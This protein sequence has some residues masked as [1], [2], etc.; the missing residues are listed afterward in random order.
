MAISNVT[1]A[2]SAFPMA[3]LIRRLA[4]IAH[5]AAP[6]YFAQAVAELDNS[7]ETAAHGLA[8]LNW[9]MATSEDVAFQEDLQ[10][11]MQATAE[12]TAVLSTLSAIRNVSSARQAPNNE[13]GAPHAN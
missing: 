11:A 2:G 10:L 12:L 13:I 9:T 7:P 5:D 4:E 8:L 1:P 6:D 3:A